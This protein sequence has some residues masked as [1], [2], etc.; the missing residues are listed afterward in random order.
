MCPRGELQLTYMTPIVLTSEF[1]LK[2]EPGTLLLA[3]GDTPRPCR[4]RT[5]GRSRAW[6]AGTCE[7]W[8]SPARLVASRPR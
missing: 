7:C 5:N 4:A 2:A 1:A 8:A 6:L 3:P